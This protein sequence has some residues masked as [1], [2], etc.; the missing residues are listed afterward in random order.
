M[1]KMGQNLRVAKLLYSTKNKTHVEKK[2]ILT[3]VIKHIEQN[4]E[5]FH[6]ITDEWIIKIKNDYSIIT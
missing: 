2:E 1:D 6:D 3:K 5:C 4:K